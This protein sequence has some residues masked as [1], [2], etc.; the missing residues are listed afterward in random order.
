MG[1]SKVVAWTFIVVGALIGTLGTLW[2]IANI[3]EGNFEMTGFLLLQVPL[4]AIVA[5]MVGGGLYTLQNAKRE[6]VAMA[7]VEKQRALLN[8]LQTRGELSIREAALELNT[9]VDSVKNDIYDLVGKGLFS[10]Y[11]NW[12]EGVLYS[13]EA[14]TMRQSGQ[15]PNC[16]GE[17]KLVGK[18]VIQC[19]WCGSEIFL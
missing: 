2:G 14:R 7:A 9:S 5:L 3:N 4:A 1:N 6:S 8:M 16:G 12:D 17:L 15:C 13:R 10:G 11:V 18:G 19:P